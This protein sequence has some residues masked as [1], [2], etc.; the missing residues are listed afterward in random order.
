MA[1]Q[2]KD[3]AT[4]RTAAVFFLVSAVFELLD[5]TSAA[6]LFGAVRVGAIAAFY[7]FVFAASYVLSGIGMWT[8]RPWGTVPL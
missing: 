4:I 3:R 7:H 1:P 8:A 2:I 5:C 6:A